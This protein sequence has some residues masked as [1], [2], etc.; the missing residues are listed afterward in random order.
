[1]AEM[2]LHRREDERQMADMTFLF[3]KFVDFV[4]DESCFLVEYKQML[5][6]R[7]TAFIK[8]QTVGVVALFP[9]RQSRVGFY[10]A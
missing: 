2:Q 10:G 9:L 1:M 8:D 4:I 5:Q 7:S 6:G 3:F